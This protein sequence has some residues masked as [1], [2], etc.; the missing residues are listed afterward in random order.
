MCKMETPTCNRCGDTYA[1]RDGCD[2]T[3]E[4]DSCAHS[5]LAELREA[6]THHLEID[7]SNTYAA[8]K[9]LVTTPLEQH[10]TVVSTPHPPQI[11]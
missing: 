7:S 4:C 1:L 5:A 10:E 9:A 11:D 8:L 2:P 6:V 3:P